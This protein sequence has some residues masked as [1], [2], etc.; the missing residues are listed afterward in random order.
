M[1]SL[2]L[3]MANSCC[4][5]GADSEA[6]ILPMHKRRTTK[7]DKKYFFIEKFYNITA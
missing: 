2:A 3:L 1:F 6:V 5:N 4:V 7:Y